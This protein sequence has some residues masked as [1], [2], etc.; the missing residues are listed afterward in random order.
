MLKA[1]LHGK[2]G[3]IET[4]KGESVS[5]SSLFKAR[6]DL[7][8]STVFERFAYLTNTTQQKILQD[9][10][11][12]HHGD[13]PSNFGELNNIN[14]WPSFIHQHERGQNRVEPDLILQFEECNIIIEVK[15]PA[16]GEQ[17]FTQW[18]K[19]IV[20]FLQSDE[21]QNKQLY[22]LAI[23]RINEADTKDWAK[24]LLEMD[25]FNQLKGVAALKWTVVVD[26]LVKLTNKT[27][28][29]SKQDNC[30]LKD[31][32]EGLSLYGLQISPFK[33]NDFMMNSFPN[34]QLET[35]ANLF[36]SMFAS[37]F[38]LMQNYSTS[39]LVTML[40]TNLPELNFNQFKSLMETN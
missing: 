39:S 28:E 22:F 36:N 24:Q 33:W 23:G 19:E 26:Q 8:T 16:G 4:N 32:L 25:E 27:A 31:I 9:W 6:E 37:S 3:R 21:S 34:I 14:Y 5:W 35:H 12:T 10:F 18:E 1:I 15:P 17:H 7:L 29:I 38:T 20:S 30:I 13:I 40:P 2:A 11:R